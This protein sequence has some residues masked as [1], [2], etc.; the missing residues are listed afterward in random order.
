MDPLFEAVVEA[1]EEAI[2][3]SMVANRAM[4]GRDGRVS[5]ALPHDELLSLLRNSGRM[6]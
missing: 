1:T 2:I 4:T 5:E 6:S 3:D